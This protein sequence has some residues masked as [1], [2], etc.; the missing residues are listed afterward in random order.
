ML[1]RIFLIIAIVAGLAAAGLGYFKVREKIIATMAERDQEKK[2]KEIAQRDL[3]STKKTLKK[4]EEDLAITKK[5][6]ATTRT[7][8]ANETKRA[9]ELDKQKTDLTA[10]VATV[11]GERDAAQNKLLAWDLI[12]KTP[13]EVRT[14]IADLKKTQQERDL[15]T[16]TNKALARDNTRLNAKLD[17]LIGDA[18]DPILPTG[19]KGKVVA[20]DPK[21][22]FVVL[23]IGEKQGVLERG[24][25]L[26][27][28]HGTLVAKVRVA[29]VGPDRSVANVLPEWKNSNLEIMEGDQVLY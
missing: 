3:A 27:N 24:V 16:S 6:L 13:E 1:T 10:Q 17:E 20:V 4:T 7:E 25:L 12:Q 21:Y 5:T 29:S 8:L 28:R 9:E 15:L 19:L 22:D 11:K 14:V 2:D 18:R 26:V 23:D